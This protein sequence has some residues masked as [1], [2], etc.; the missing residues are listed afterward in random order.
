M[1]RLTQRLRFVYGGW[2]ST[3][4]VSAKSYDTINILTLPA[5]TWVSVRYQPENA[6][7]G[8]SCNAV[9]GSQIL[10]I[11]G[12]NPNPSQANGPTLSDSSSSFDDPDPNAQGLAIFD[13]TNLTWSSQYTANAPP[14]EQ[15]GLIRQVYSGPQYVSIA[16]LDAIL[17]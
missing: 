2:Y 5:F 9:G 14:Y 4:G 12:L 6:R 16:L 17:L 7:Y 8:H 3:L 13:M 15:S 11:G 10:T 1:G